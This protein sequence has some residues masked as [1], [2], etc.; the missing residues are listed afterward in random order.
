MVAEPVSVAELLTVAEPITVAEPVTVAEPLTLAR[1]ATNASAK[2]R[3]AATLLE[4]DCVLLRQLGTVPFDLGS[5]P[6]VFVS[7][8]S[9]RNWY[10]T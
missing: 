5:E 2:E 1:A 4:D 3:Y 8:R 9:I 7:M 6:I 10:Q